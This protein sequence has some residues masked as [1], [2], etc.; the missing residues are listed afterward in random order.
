MPEV[1]KSDV[2]SLA[3]KLQEFAKDL[4]EHEQNVLG[5]LLSRAQASTSSGELSE[6]ALDA[7]A[8]GQEAMSSQLADSLGFT[9][10]EEAVEVTGQVGVKWPR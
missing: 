3:G 7:V 6:A 1:K 10:E 5:W 4:P 2:D 9:G 8:G